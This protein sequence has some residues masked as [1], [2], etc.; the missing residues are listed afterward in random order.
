MD[1]GLL[2][3]AEFPPEG[4]V[5]L[6]GQGAVDVIRRALVVPGGKPGAVHVDALEGHQGG[7]G[8]VEM[9]ISPGR[10]PPGDVLGQIVGS[11]GAGGHNDLPLLRQ[12]LHLAGLEGDVG[13]PLDGLGDGLGKGHP[14]HRQSPPGGHPMGVGTPEDQG[15]QPPQFLFQQA[16]RILQLVRPQGVG[17]HQFPQQGGVVGRGHL[18]RLHLPQRHGDPPVGQLPSGL[19]P[20]QARA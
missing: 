6:L 4:Q 19:A 13:M 2:G 14:V 20:G 15:V 16:H 1:R 11:E 5:L 9:Q 17:A 10:E 18:V 8:I 3:G 7:S 12:S